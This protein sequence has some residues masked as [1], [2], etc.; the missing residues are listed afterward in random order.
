MTPQSLLEGIV[1]AIALLE[2]SIL[3]NR[4]THF[5]PATACVISSIRT[6]LSATDCMSKESAVL[7]AHPVLAKERTQIL[8]EL[9]R[10][11]DKA[12]LASAPTE[13]E[14]SRKREMDNML[15]MARVVLGSVQRF[16]SIAVECG[17]ELPSQR[18]SSATRSEGVT[19]TVTGTPPRALSPKS[20]RRTSTSS[21]SSAT[22]S[23][24]IGRAS[25]PRA[26]P[27]SNKRLQD[28]FKAKEASAL[29][30]RA[31]SLGDLR[32][33]RRAGSGS[34]PPPMPDSAA[35]Y[36]TALASA[37][38]IASS[39]R[40]SVSTSV[41]SHRS[42]KSS[43]NHLNGSFDSTSSVDDS[44]QGPLTPVPLPV[45]ANGRIDILA[46]IG[47][48]EDSLLSVI[49]AFIGHVHSH[50]SRSH[51]SSHAHMLDLTRETIDTVREL[52]TVVEAVARHPKVKGTKPRELASLR[53]SKGQLYDNATKLV[54]AAEIVV[55]TQRSSDEASEDG[56]DVDR[57][58]LLQSATGTLRSG[59]ECV[60]LVRLC[61][62]RSN[63]HS[64]VDLNMKAL[65]KP[66]G[67][68]D[69][70][71]KVSY[72]SFAEQQQTPPT[73]PRD[74]SVGA[75]GPHTLSSLDRKA[76]SL[77]NLK[78]R[79]QHDGLLS[80]SSSTFDHD[81]DEEEEIKDASDEDMTVQPSADGALRDALANQQTPVNKSRLFTSRTSPQLDSNATPQS[82]ST[83]IIDR[84]PPLTRSRASSLTSPAPARA[85]PQRSPSRS[86]DLDKVPGGI[87]LPAKR[88]S[89]GSSS[90]TSQSSTDPSAFSEMSTAETS[91]R[92]SMA[93]SK[94][95][96]W[97]G[98]SQNDS[99][100]LE[101]LKTTI[102]SADSFPKLAEL[103]LE[104]M[105]SPKQPSPSALPEPS[106]LPRS[107][108]ADA[109][110][111]LV[112]HDYNPRDIAFSS[113]GHIIGATIEVLVEK[114]TPHDTIVDPVFHKTFFLTFRLFV[115]PSDLLA[116]VVKRYDLRPPAGV[117]LA[118]H[119][120][121]VWVDQ[122]VTPVRLRIYNFLKAW[123]DTH[124]RPVTDAV[125]L[126]AMLSFAKIDMTKTLPAVAPRLVDSITRRM[127]NG[128]PQPAER[129]ILDRSKSTD[130]IRLGTP[131]HQ[132]SSFKS[133]GYTFSQP[134]PT[135][136]M[137]KSLITNL[138]ANATISVTDFDTLELARQMSIM[139]SR[140]YCAIAPE[141]LLQTCTRPVPEV[142]AMSTLSTQITGW[143]SDSI[144]NEQDAK[145]R[146][147]L[148]KFFIKLADVS[149]AVSG[150]GITNI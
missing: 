37:R 128:L 29:A 145:R 68:F 142:K 89:R 141:D 120:H 74:E 33:R 57:S 129:R 79:Y 81:D 96:R 140:L 92:S 117:E 91:T 40:S 98:S 18:A 65:S 43:G 23:I 124:W 64:S 14:E 54:E 7:R 55:Q 84:A 47:A 42:R 116:A 49:A 21:Q 10:L 136:I 122:K 132:M 66:T 105:P 50:S 99:P 6:V 38:S 78:K 130:G 4:V 93:S 112:T 113:E 62:A 53:Q 131:N 133:S 80:A 67:N 86:A 147:Q 44:P 104:T 16:L 82:R 69:D 41:Q 106:A 123:L 95:S 58:L 110:V 52:L 59:T 87:N 35:S 135:P 24:G 94:Q 102:A 77:S 97:T 114:M 121:S 11:V 115:S 34:P 134:P 139:E 5:Q 143:V 30:F 70:E 148:L 137:T 1:H 72:A 111:W 13:V 75:R 25:L 9:S 19:N 150:I 46:A 85:I 127:A 108:S 12:R 126:D 17:V 45:D 144:L 73:Q 138:R 101:Y 27:G 119:E 56:E 107:A 28:K 36:V 90:A 51:P 63:H 3:A 146:A 71:P 60:R 88:L 15:R 8:K 76:T 31:T 26:S 118:P 2:N 100:T 103:N 125:V 20:R 83:S 22:A 32:S 149:V 61:I 109:R 39:A 48:T